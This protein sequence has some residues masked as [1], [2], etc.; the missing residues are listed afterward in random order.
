MFFNQ[1]FKNKNIFC[2]SKKNIC[3]HNI[4]I[5]SSKKTMILTFSRHDIIFKNVL[6]FKNNL[7]TFLIFF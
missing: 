3:E 6:I 7:C 5:E 2:T 1:F 4:F